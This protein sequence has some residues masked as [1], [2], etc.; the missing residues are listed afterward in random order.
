M[1]VDKKAFGFDCLNFYICSINK[2]MRFIITLC[3]LT[4]LNAANGQDSIF[5]RG[6][7]VI[8]ASIQTVEET[9]IQYKLFGYPTGPL[10]IK[11]ISEINRIR[12]QNGV[13]DTFRVM[14]EVITDISGIAYTPQQLDSITTADVLQ[15][16]Q[17][18]RTGTAILFSSFLLTP[19][20][21]L[22]P[23]SMAY[24]TMP[25]NVN[26]NIPDKPLAKT[27]EY[28]KQYKQKAYTVKQQAVKRNYAAS[29]ISTAI[30]GFFGFLLTR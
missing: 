18:S 29:L 28:Y 19:V 6:G 16:Y 2:I 27:E 15:N 9:K 1:N 5:F 17:K 4:I 10:F 30:I 26:L 11:S 7:K 20:L 14:P 8:S 23:T 3:F 12:Y 22:I 21:G 25:K 13:I 24:S